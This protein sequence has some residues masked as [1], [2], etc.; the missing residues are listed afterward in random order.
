MLLQADALKICEIILKMNIALKQ[1]SKGILHK[2]NVYCVHGQVYW[3]DSSSNVAKE[4]L[5]TD[6]GKESDLNVVTS[7]QMLSQKAVLASWCIST[8]RQFLTRVR[9]IYTTHKRVTYLATKFLCNVLIHLQ[10]GR[11][12]F[13]CHAEDKEYYTTLSS[14]GRFQSRAYYHETNCLMQKAQQFTESESNVPILKTK[15][16][17]ML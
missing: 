4:V 13:C 15:W 12:C 5:L 2:K 7:V 17:E 14:E 8:P 3:R 16:N 1:C 11:F 6:A 10:G 9:K